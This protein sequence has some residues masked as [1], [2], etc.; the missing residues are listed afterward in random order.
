MTCVSGWCLTILV[1]A[2]AGGRTADR[3]PAMADPALV[4]ETEKRLRSQKGVHGFL[5][6]NGDGIA[7]RSSMQ[8]A[9]TVHY[10]ALVSRFVE[11]SRSCIKR[12]DGDDELNFVRIRSQKHEIMVAPDFGGNTD[13]YLVVVQDPTTE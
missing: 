6:L 9:E 3:Q 7:I 4:E 8:N 5:V 13:Y 10:A 2:S 1:P 11:K 12:L